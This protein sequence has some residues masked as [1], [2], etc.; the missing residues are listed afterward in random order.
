MTLIGRSMCLDHCQTKQLEPSKRLNGSSTVQQ[1]LDCSLALPAAFV[2]L[3]FRFICGEK[4]NAAARNDLERAALLEFFLRKTNSARPFL[5]SPAFRNELETTP[6][7]PHP[8][9]KVVAR[10]EL[11]FRVAEY[12]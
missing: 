10:D 6:N 3:E 2:F 8:E 12:D 7:S 4:T 9:R 11:F 5:A 1:H